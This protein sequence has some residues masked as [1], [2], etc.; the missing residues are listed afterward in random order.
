MEQAVFQVWRDEYDFT[1][2]WAACGVSGQCPRGFGRLD[3]SPAVCLCL[4]DCRIPD[5]AVSHLPEGGLF[6]EN[7]VFAALFEDR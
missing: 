6:I 3:L 2:S 4:G 5:D 7:Q 1:G